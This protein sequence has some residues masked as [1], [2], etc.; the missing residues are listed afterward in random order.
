MF[1]LILFCRIK[2]SFKLLDNGLV[3]DFYL[4]IYLEMIHLRDG[5]NNIQHGAPQFEWIVG[6]L[7]LIV[8]D[9]GFWD[10]KPTYYVLP[11]KFQNILGNN[12]DGGFGFD[13]FSEIIDC[14]N[15]K[16]VPSRGHWEGAHKINSPLS[17]KP[18]SLDWDQPVLRLLNYRGM[19]LAFGTFLNEGVD[20]GNNEDQ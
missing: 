16:L 4:P 3:V 10:V 11:N 13:P 1:N 5:L 14:D 18:W 7:F 6:N 12:D 8:R 15:Q 2:A 20:A 17:E 9:D 19:N